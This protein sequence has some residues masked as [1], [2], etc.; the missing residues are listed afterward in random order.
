MLEQDA[1]APTL[2]VLELAPQ[3]LLTMLRPSPG[4]TEAET[5]DTAWLPVLVNV[6]VLLAELPAATAPKLKEEPLA[7]LNV[8]YPRR[9]VPVKVTT[10]GLPLTLLAKF[11]LAAEAGP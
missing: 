6:N 2:T 8:P 10:V 11:K 7:A 1:P 5:P 3:V 4:V 9:P